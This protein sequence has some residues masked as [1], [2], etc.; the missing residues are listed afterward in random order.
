MTMAV[1]ILC[2]HKW[3]CS[4]LKIDQ[5]KYN[6]WSSLQRTTPLSFSLVQT[7]VKNK[8]VR[9]LSLPL[10][11]TSS[12]FRAAFI[13]YALV[14]PYDYILYLQQYINRSW[15]YVCVYVYINTHAWHNSHRFKRSKVAMNSWF[16]YTLYCTIASMSIEWVNRK[17]IQ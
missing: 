15:M 3:I 11:F 6:V 8:I 7:N 16:T 9:S 12:L 1:C 17:I 14:D 10:S 13:R 2:S 4:T 5:L